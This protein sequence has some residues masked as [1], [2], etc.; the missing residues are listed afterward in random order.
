MPLP[1]SGSAVEGVQVKFA[2]LVIAVS[3]TPVGIVSTMVVGSVLAT[4]PL[5]EACTV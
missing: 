1:I 3:V 4:G 2:P 5:F